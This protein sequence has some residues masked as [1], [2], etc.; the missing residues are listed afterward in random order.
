MIAW[1]AVIVGLIV[2]IGSIIVIG[3]EHSP[4]PKAS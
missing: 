2:V 3:R 1:S 4:K